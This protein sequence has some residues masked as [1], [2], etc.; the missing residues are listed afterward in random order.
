MIYLKNI[1]IIVAVLVTL[2]VIMCVVSWIVETIDTSRK[3]KELEIYI[4][5]RDSKYKLGDIVEINRHGPRASRS[6]K[7]RGLISKVRFSETTIVYL[8]E[9]GYGCVL[10]DE[11]EIV[12]KCKFQY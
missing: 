7:I 2:F 11:E 6:K 1:G 8:V 12:R 9:Y 3:L 10:L 5:T 4:L